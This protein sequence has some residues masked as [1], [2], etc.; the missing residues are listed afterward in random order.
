MLDLASRYKKALKIDRL[1][2]LSGEN[3]PI[4]LLEVGT[5]SG[6]IAQYFTDHETI[7]FKVTAVDVVDQRL[8][9]EKYDFVLVQDTHLPFA[10]QSFD[11]VISNHVIDH[12]GDRHAQ[13][14]H[15]SEIYRVLKKNGV[16]Y[17]SV[18]N[19]WMIV[20]PHY[21]LMFLSWLPRK[22]RT[23][24]LRLR[25]RGDFYDCEPLTK[26]E[27]ES[28]FEKND[29]M[30]KNI[31]PLALKETVLIEKKYGKFD[32]AFLNLPNSILDKLTPVFP[33]LIYKLYRNT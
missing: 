21:H 5:G 7:D 23:R 28:L 30:Y 32:F 27:L 9:R 2:E 17:F 14:H 13:S 6:G 12:V 1:L 19:R 11:V 29:F 15:L 33:T 16:G 4:C 3:Q 25:K 31:C 26:R 18:F 8:L 24:Y 22:F 10:D 20:E